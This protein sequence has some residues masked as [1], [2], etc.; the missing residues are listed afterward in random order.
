MARPLGL[1]K[2]ATPPGPS[3]EPDEPE[4]ARVLTA[5]VCTTME[6]TLSLLR[7]ATYIVL[8]LPS[9]TS[10]YGMKKRALVPPASM[11]PNAAPPPASVLTSTAASAKPGSSEGI[12]AFVQ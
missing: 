12:F 7:S 4:P 5:P 9:R 11:S 8:P 10:A 6:R 2:L 1:K 3:A